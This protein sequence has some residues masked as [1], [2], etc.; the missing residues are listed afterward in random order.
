MTL[1]FCASDLGFNAAADVSIQKKAYVEYYA[2]SDI[3]LDTI[4]CVL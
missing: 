3:I 1:A 2:G 4:M